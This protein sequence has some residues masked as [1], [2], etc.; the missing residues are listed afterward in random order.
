MSI[1]NYRPKFMALSTL[2]LLLALSF[3]AAPQAQKNEPAREPTI[4][5]ATI[6]DGKAGARA[7]AGFEFFVIAENKIGVRSPRR[8]NATI[9]GH[10]FCLCG[11]PTGSGSCSVERLNNSQVRCKSSGCNNCNMN[12]R[13]QP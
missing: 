4:E 5:E 9:K 10:L 1:I 13:T 6:R 8:K 3:A 7:K 12:F 2:S 11:D